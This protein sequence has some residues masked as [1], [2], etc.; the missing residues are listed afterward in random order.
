MTPR[1]V[2]VVLGFWALPGC[3]LPTPGLKDPTHRT[4]TPDAGSFPVEIGRT[5]R[6]DILL[7]LGEPDW[8][9]PFGGGVLYVSAFVDVLI[10]VAGQGGGFIVPIGHHRML[11]IDFGEDGR[12]KRVSTRSPGGLVKFENR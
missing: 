10:L 3:I 11:A 4:N 1:R 12:V 2:L 9:T 6:E 8:N 7:A 5:T